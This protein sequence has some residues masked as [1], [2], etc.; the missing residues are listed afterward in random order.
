MQYQLASA[1]ITIG[2][3]ADRAV[4]KEGDFIPYLEINYLP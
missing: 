2:T 3:T 4:T 1:A